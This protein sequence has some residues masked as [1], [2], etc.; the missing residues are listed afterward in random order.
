MSTCARECGTVAARIATA[1]PPSTASHSDSTRSA[2]SFPRRR[3]L[4]LRPSSAPWS[5]GLLMRRT[6]SSMVARAAASER[7]TKGRAC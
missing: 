6:S 4:R 7:P 3:A 1:V 2:T 5:T